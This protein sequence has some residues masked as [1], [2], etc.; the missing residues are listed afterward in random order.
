MFA[1]NSIEWTTILPA[2]LLGL[3]GL[4]PIL[5]GQSP[6]AI[7]QRF[8]P[9]LC[10]L[11]VLLVWT[12]Y[13]ST[14]V[15]YQWLF[16][17][18]GLAFVGLLVAIGCF[19]WLVYK[20]LIAPAPLIQ[21]ADEAKPEAPLEAVD[22]AKAAELAKAAALTRRMFTA[23]CSGIMAVTVA[24]SVLSAGEG[25]AVIDVHIA[26]STPDA[27]KNSKLESATLLPESGSGETPVAFPASKTLFR[28]GK[29]RLV[30]PKAKFDDSA[31]QRI[32]ISLIDQAV[33][34]GGRNGLRRILTPGAVEYY[35]IQ[36]KKK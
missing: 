34:E 17:S 25:W 24:A 29:H 7:D 26:A 10:T 9:L 3:G 5:I 8:K 21:A 6:F 14:Y 15:L 22:A 27:A 33:Y 18:D 32:Q 19:G 11:F 20:P 13:L 36:L 35:E 28:S 30:L 23:Y 2:G 12:A 1:M 16:F 4:L 31:W